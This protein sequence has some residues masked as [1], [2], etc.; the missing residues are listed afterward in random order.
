MRR[1]APQ[2]ASTNLDGCAAG[3]SVRPG[4][5]ASFA[6]ETPDPMR[7][8]RNRDPNGVPQCAGQMRSHG[9][10]RDQQVGCGERR[11]IFVERQRRLARIDDAWRRR[12]QRSASR[13]VLQIDDVDTLE[14]EERRDVAELHRLVGKSRAFGIG[15]KHQ[16]DLR[17]ARASGGGEP[18]APRS[19][20]AG[21]HAP[22]RPMRGHVRQVG[23]EPVR[24]AQPRQ[25]CVERQRR[26]VDLRQR[27]VG[28]RRQQ[29]L[30][31]GN[32]RKKRSQ[33]RVRGHD[34]AR[35]ASRQQ[36]NVAGAHDAVAEALLGEEQNA[37][38][39][40]RLSG[41][42]KPVPQRRAAFQGR[43]PRPRRLVEAGFVERQ[44]LVVAAE[45]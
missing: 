28:R 19:N 18:A 15:L 44:A 24:Q 45:P 43:E 21:V 20:A 8:M 3:K 10:H 9:V 5:R 42:E 1:R 41:A 31:A 27:L 12:G 36:R 30:D 33:R 6:V 32:T 14:R 35:A 23:A 29:R 39:V 40:D 34:D 7:R 16:A 37:A 4:T 13:T 22:V 2:S 17:C 11:A 25:P 38:A 26:E